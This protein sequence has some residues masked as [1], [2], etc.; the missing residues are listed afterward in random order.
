MSLESDLSSSGEGGQFSSSLGN[1][2][3]FSASEGAH[4]L[5][6]LRVREAFSLLQH[7]QQRGRA[8]GFLSQ[9]SPSFNCHQTVF[10]SFVN[11][12]RKD[13][14]SSSFSGLKRCDSVWS[15]PVCSMAIQHFRFWELRQAVSLH[16]KAGGEVYM[17]TFTARHL[18]HE[19]LNK[20]M[21]DLFEAYQLVHKQGNV[22]RWLK[23]NGVGSIR[24]LEVMYGSN[25]WHP[26]FHVLYFLNSGV[27]VD[28]LKFLLNSAYL[29]QLKKLGRPSQSGI[30]LNIQDGRSVRDYMTKLVSEMTLSNIKTGRDDGHYSPFQL[31]SLS[32]DDSNYWALWVEFVKAIKGKSSLQWSRGLRDY[33]KL[34]ELNNSEITDKTSDLWV[35]LIARS[36]FDNISH[37]IKADILLLARLTDNYDEFANSVY[38][39]LGFKV[40]KASSFKFSIKKIKLNNINIERKEVISKHSLRN[41]E[42]DL[43]FNRKQW[44]P[45][46]EDLNF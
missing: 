24:N 29:R 30:A 33:F 8:V 9:G 14:G 39:G 32:R 25:G 12:H 43:K 2:R 41:Q 15:C 10:G 11:V 31:L 17:A 45:S 26:H 21:S 23:E 4:A 3:K 20:V 40:D 5:T 36:I 38:S 42:N 34:N 22:Y 19:R 44:K 27:K 6:R 28:N 1:I 35:A 37:N 18:K 46:K 13:T 7:Y 16:V